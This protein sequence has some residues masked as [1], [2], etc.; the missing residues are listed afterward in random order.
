M[1]GMRIAAAAAISLGVCVLNH[2]AQ[3][4]TTYTVVPG[5]CGGV[6]NLLQCAVNLSPANPI[7]IYPTLELTDDLVEDT[8]GLVDWSTTHGPTG[9][10][11]GKGF[12]KENS[13]GH[14]LSYPVRSKVCSNGSCAEQVTALTVYFEG[15]YIGGGIYAGY[16]TLHMSYQRQYS[17]AGGWKWVRTV[18]GGLVTLTQ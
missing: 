4:E 9:R 6:A 8:G 14:Y 12:I 15:E 5:Q 3:A 13:Q 2:S 18:T 7:G 17:L 10:N 11:L 1:R 16:Y